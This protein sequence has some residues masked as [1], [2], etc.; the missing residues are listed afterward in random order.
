MGWG[1]LA[2]TFASTVALLTGV[3]PAA[4][5]FHDGGVGACDG[6][7]ELHSSGGNPD[8]LLRGSDISS[9]CLRCHAETGEQHGVLSG[10]GSSFT[11]GGDF[12]WLR[13]SYVWIE[14][15][16]VHTSPADSH[17][18]NVVAVEYGLIPDAGL[19]A[20]PGSGYP[21]SDLSCASCHDP[22]GQRTAEADGA[23]PVSSS[24]SYQKT[25]LE[26][27]S[28]GNY[29]LL[30]GTGYDSSGIVFSND[31]PIALAPTSWGETDEN[32]V[33]YG[34]GMSEWCANCHD[35]M[36]DGAS[37]QHPSGAA[38]VFSDWTA[39]AYDAYV[40]TGDVSGRAD[41][42]YLALVPFERGVFDPSLLDP[43][44]TAGPEP[45][46]SNVMCLTCHRAHASAFQAIGRWDWTATFLAESRPGMG[47]GGDAWNSY[48]G[49]DLEAEFGP[50]QRSLCNKCH[51]AD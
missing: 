6:C 20:A 17:G 21:S 33:D 35:A 28:A 30:G 16:Q 39:A 48:Y 5:A 41:S 10:D 26:D 18:H 50:R 40:R 36:L 15:G 44:S 45:G 22:H 32:H 2:L 49:R 51:V 8:G 31:A 14:G 11:A 23:I 12:Y 46:V 43:T 3:L 7:H 1:Q 29:R 24:G 25:S 37:L 42:S 9:T 27:A 38:A 19:P 47:D 4:N 13:R 34:S